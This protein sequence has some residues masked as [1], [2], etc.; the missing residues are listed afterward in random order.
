M[1]ENNNADGSETNTYKY[2]VGEEHLQALD[3]W[4]FMTTWERKSGEPTNLSTWMSKFPQNITELNSYRNRGLFG[5]KKLSEIS[6]HTYKTSGIKEA[7]AIVFSTV[8]NYFRT[9]DDEIKFPGYVQAVN[10]NFVRMRLNINYENIG[11]MMPRDFEDVGGDN[12]IYIPYPDLISLNAY[13]ENGT[14]IHGFAP[15]GNTYKSSHIVISGLSGDSNYSNSLHKVLIEDKFSE[16]EI[17]PRAFADRPNGNYNEVGNYLGSS[18]I[19]QIRLFNKSLITEGEGSDTLYYKQ[20][21]LHTLLG[22][23]KKVA[24]PDEGEE[25][26]QYRDNFHP[27]WE[28]YSGQSWG[29]D[30]FAGDRNDCFP[31]ESPV[32]N[33]F[34]GE[35]DQ[36]RNI[37]LFEIQ[38]DELVEKSFRD[39]SGNNVKGHLI[40]DYSI[41]KERKDTAAARDSH[42]K[43]GKVEIATNH[44]KN[45]AF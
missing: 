45:G 13:H 35:Y 43:I 41:K 38:S 37:C 7:Q 29:C 12:F 26:A 21:D 10:W 4:Y 16:T 6:S 42:I 5:I 22:I 44:K 36:Y 9:N 15:S 3:W 33:L 23:D 28:Y 11:T 31:L 20:L 39:T 14:H 34:I 25:I 2:K 30:D 1:E 27:Y 18:N 24:I 40:G 32:G 8:K 19:S 17:T